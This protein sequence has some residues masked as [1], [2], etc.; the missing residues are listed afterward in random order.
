MRGSK[1]KDRQKEEENK[2]ETFKPIEMAATP[3][4]CQFLATQSSRPVTALKSLPLS[5][6]ETLLKIT[7]IHF[8][9]NITILPIS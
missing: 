5:M 7:E 6:T 9:L 3:S 8:S 1:L 2:K 4:K